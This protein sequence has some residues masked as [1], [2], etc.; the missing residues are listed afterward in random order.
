MSI[1]ITGPQGCGKST[2]KEALAV[3]FGM[4]QVIDEWQP[5][6]HLPETAIAFTNC[7]GIEG[8]IEFDKATK[9]LMAS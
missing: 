6:D 7:Q 8:T 1:V 9:L 3:Y 5:G 2:N 4:K